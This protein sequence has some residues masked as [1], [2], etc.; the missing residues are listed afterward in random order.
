M[1]CILFLS[2]SVNRRFLQMYNRSG[3][4]LP[5]LERLARHSVI[6]D[7]HWTGS[8]PCM[9]A[10]RDIM[11]GRLNFL[12]RNWGGIEPFD[13]TLPEML[14]EVGVHSHITT[15]HYHYFE[16]GGENYCSNFDT[17]EL[18]RGQ[19]WDPWIS[20]VNRK[21]EIPDHYGMMLEQCVL[22]R[23][24][25]KNDETLYPSVKTVCSAAQWLEKNH[26]ADK[27]LLWVEPF[28]PHEPYD[29]PQKYLDM[30]GDDYDDLLYMWP[31]YQEVS[32]CDMPTEKC[33]KHIRNRCLALMLMTDHW[34][35]KL[36]DVM[37]A[38]DMWDDTMFIF[39]TDH[40]FLLGEH[41]YMGKTYMPAYNEEFHIPLLVHMPGD[42]GAG[43]RCNALTQNIDIYPSLAEYFGVD[44]ETLPNKLHGKSWLPLIR[45]EKGKIRECA[46]YGQ[47][48]KQVN[49]T[50]GRYTY[51][52]APAADNKPLN[53]YTAM[54]TDD[55]PFNYY[56]PSRLTDLTRITAG[57]YLSWHQYPV[58]RIPVDIIKCPNVE[59]PMQFVVLREWD[60]QDYLFDLESDYAQ[61]KNLVEERPDEV[62]RMNSLMVRALQEHDAPAE[63]LTRLRLL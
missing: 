59:H 36:L 37:D 62:E 49:L 63:Q 32:R 33:L 41:G 19:E 29:V 52:R 9:P 18:H 7:N 55:P 16:A 2:D 58:F 26:D 24:E 54:P 43:S 34:M 44:A 25:F 39:T 31:E 30:V 6:F 46:L 38:H 14:R 45:G 42:V 40:G 22:N 4:Y 20:R 5:N 47:F 56:K 3:L 60:K 21:V 15:D 10:R 51:F 35:G 50:D 11:T 28:D 48:G 57:P 23:E 12:E 8:A 17:W 61:T 13:Y 27:F 53:V 1:K